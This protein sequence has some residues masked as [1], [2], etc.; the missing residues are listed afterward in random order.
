MEIDVVDV[1]AG[2]TQVVLSLFFVSVSVI[3]CLF[4]QAAATNTT[5]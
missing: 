2:G 5:S 4:V 3:T 1:P